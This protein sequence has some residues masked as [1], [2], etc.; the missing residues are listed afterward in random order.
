MFRWNRLWLGAKLLAFSLA[1]LWHGTPARAYIDLASTLPRIMADSLKITVVEVVEVKKE[2]RALVLKEI[3]ALKG[4]LSNEPIRQIVALGEGA[5]IPRHILTWATPG[6]RAIVFSSRGNAL[7]CLGEGWYQVT[8]SG[9]GPWQIAKDRPDLP[10]AYH[11]SL[12]RLTE[13]IERM[14]A[15]KDSVLT[16]VAYGTDN[17]GASF[18]L[19]LNRPNLPGLVRVQRIRGNMNMPGMV[20]AASANPSYLIG[21]GSVDEG[22]LAKLL[23]QLKSMDTMAKAEAA[24]DL[25]SLGRKAN[26]AAPSLAALLADPSPRV[27]YSA[28]AALLQINSRDKQPVEVLARGLDSPDKAEKRMATRAAG[29]SGAAA[30]SLVVKLATL[31]K[32]EDD[33]LRITAL[34]ALALLGPIAGDAAKDITPLLDNRELTIDAAD[35]LGRMGKSARPALK[36]L[37]QFLSDKET[38]FQWAAVRAM[39]QIG[40]D[41]A[42]PAVDFM[43]RTLPNA[44]EVDRYNM[45]IYLAL[46]GPVAKDAAT[47]IRRSGSRNPV[48]PTATL[49]AIEPDKSFPW[50]GGRFGPGLGG[51]P[52]GFGGMPN[53]ATLIYENY[54]HELGERLK[55][56]VRVLAEQLLDGTAGDVPLW[57]YKILACSPE[58]A[59]EILKPALLH[60]DLAMRE[61]AVVAFG[62]MG[63]AA[64]P[65]MESLKTAQDATT[66]EKEK[67]LIGWSLR[68]ISKD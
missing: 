1:F 10:L 16:V 44:P 53:I 57:G 55:P 31:L 24:E 67:R 58:T 12:S 59:I 52:G 68:E 7:V 51:P 23:E 65:V 37:T 4:E 19:A 15:G 43:I 5:T 45:M 29:Q 3:R 36:K 2:K 62:F 17:E 61:R 18:D 66:N 25:R 38:A 35:A 46:L 33:A 9:T 47:T 49:W 21:P 20:M 60:K 42:K 39:S 50:Q 30:A 32:D 56:A 6:A 41:D 8:S 34:H 26:K 48:L 14:L 63:S 40:G 27:R 13:G 54:V 11:G 28:A 22:D 64:K